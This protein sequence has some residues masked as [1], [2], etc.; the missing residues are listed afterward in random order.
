MLEATGPCYLAL[1]YHLVAAGAQVAVLNPLVVKRFVQVRPGKGKPD[2]RDARRLLPHGQRPAAPRWQPEGAVLAERRQVEQ[3]AELLVRQKTMV[4]NALEALP[5][6][7]CIRPAAAQLRQ[8]LL[9]FEERAQQPGAKPLATVGAQ[10]P[11]ETPL[12]CSVPGTGRKTAACLPLCAG[13]FARFQSHRRL[14][15]KA[16]LRP[17]EFSPGTGVRGEAR[18]T[19]MGGALIRSNSFTCSWSARRANGACRALYDR[20]VAKDKNGQLALVAACN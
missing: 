13:G 15:A 6:Q 10:Q 16:G 7:P 8:A 12:P 18:T 17:R 3:V 5:A 11:P 14:I 9:P 1:A 20:R 4:H 19:T 2:R